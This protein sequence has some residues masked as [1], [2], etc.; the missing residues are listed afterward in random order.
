MLVLNGRNFSTVQ[1]YRETVSAVDYPGFFRSQVFTLSF[2]FQSTLSLPET[3]ADRMLW[4]EK[5]TS[6]ATGKI[7]YGTWIVPNA[8]TATWDLVLRKHVWGTGWTDILTLSDLISDAMNWFTIRRNGDTTYM[9]VQNHVSGNLPGTTEVNSSAAW[10]LANFDESVDGRRHGLQWG[11]DVSDA[12]AK[13]YVPLWYGTRKFLSDTE[14]SVIYDDNRPNART[15]EKMI[16]DD[17]FAQLHEFHHENWTIGYKGYQTDLAA[18]SGPLDMHSTR[19]YTVIENTIQSSPAPTPDSDGLPSDDTWFNFY[20]LEGSTDR[21]IDSSVLTS[22]KDVLEVFLFDVAPDNV[23]PMIGKVNGTEMFS[24]TDDTHD[25]SG[26]GENRDLND[27][28]QAY[29]EVEAA[30]STAAANA[31][32]GVANRSEIV[33]DDSGTTADSNNVISGTLVPGL[34]SHAGGDAKGVAVYGSG[35]AGYRTDGPAPA[36]LQLH[37]RSHTQIAIYSAVPMTSNI[38]MFMGLWGEWVRNGTAEAA[39]DFLGAAEY[40]E[41]VLTQFGRGRIVSVWLA[42][43]NQRVRV[44]VSPHGGGGG[45]DTLGYSN[46]YSSHNCYSGQMHHY[47]YVSVAAQT[48]NVETGVTKAYVDG[49]LVERILPGSSLDGAN[50]YTVPGGSLHAGTKEPYRLLTTLNWQEGNNG[51]GP[52][53]TPFRGLAHAAVVVGRE[54]S[55]AELRGLTQDLTGIPGYGKNKLPIGMAIGRGITK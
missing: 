21:V 44:H 53:D 3:H 55:E 26:T 17:P 11:T 19:P 14:R 24:P 36:H 47:G 50:P 31:I 5:S 25:G 42:M 41:P 6:M 23:T 33:L 34:F 49:Q 12:D 48:F 10:D 29:D 7:S 15:I 35:V 16:Q 30:Y 52:S 13:G 46:L 8:S 40:W 32:F 9:S 43:T 54:M 28:L 2:A 27:L 45:G 38:G 20:P 51:P 22:I 4:W 1:R 37:N 18:G 39:E